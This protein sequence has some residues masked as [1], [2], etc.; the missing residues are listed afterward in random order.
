[1]TKYEIADKILA[2]CDYGAD[3][4]IDKIFELADEVRNSIEEPNEFY[5]KDW[6][7]LQG[8]V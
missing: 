2:L 8:G 6:S 5:Y 1:M 7:G 4:I 3:E